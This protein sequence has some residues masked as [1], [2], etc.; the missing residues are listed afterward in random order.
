MGFQPILHAPEHGLKARATSKM[1]RRNELY[2]LKKIA[3]TKLRRAAEPF[4]ADLSD[5]ELLK[6]RMC[7]LHVKLEGT[8]LEERID[9]LHAELDAK[10]FAFRPHFWLSHGWFTPDGTPGIAIPFYLAH[11]R[12][13]RLERSQMLEVEGGTE[14]WCM[15]ILRHE[16]GHTLDNAYRLHHRKRYREL[17]GSWSVKYPKFYQPKPYSKSYVVHLDMWYAQAHPAAEVAE[18][19]ARWL[20]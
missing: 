14:Q 2:P 5:Q 17:F 10:G 7:D 13:K 15:R 9:R 3:R 1:E 16:V 4:W 19:V 6:V 18:T 11:P 12:L 20:H 8:E